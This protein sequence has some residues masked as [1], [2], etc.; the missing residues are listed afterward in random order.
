MLLS[1]SYIFQRSDA[2]AI[3]N[4]IK[5]LGMNTNV[6]NNDEFWNGINVLHNDVSKTGAL[7]LGI[8]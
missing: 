1:S 6:V 5:K 8:E 7:D 3:T 4:N 2:H